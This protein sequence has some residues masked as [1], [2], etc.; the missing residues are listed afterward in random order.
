MLSPT[1]GGEGDAGLSVIEVVVSAGV[2]T[3]A[4]LAVAGL[5]TN[6]LATLRDAR[7][8]QQAT[9][10][11]SRALESARGLDYQDLVMATADAPLLTYDPDGP[12]PMAGE[13]PTIDLTRPGGVVAGA[14]YWTVPQ[15]EQGGVSVE[16]YVTS[17]PGTGVPAARRVT[18]VATW[19]GRSQQ[20]ELRQ[21]TV[22]A[23][24]LG[25]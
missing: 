18:A 12:G 1:G 15:P 17:V 24:P 23:P 10:A 20:R 22:V 19:P 11:A 9:A 21:S 6:S 8:R 4:L 3:V 14:P 5:L 16:T 25:T 2:L 13:T 7:G